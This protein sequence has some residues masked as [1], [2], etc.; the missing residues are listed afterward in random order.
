[1][2]QNM[3][4]PHTD[5]KFLGIASGCLAFFLLSMMLGTSKMVHGEH[6][7][8]EIVFYRNAL[9]A[10]VLGISFIIKKRF[11]LFKTDRPFVL[12]ARV[13]VGSVGL[14]TTFAAVQFLP[15][16]TATTIFFVSTLIVPIMAVLFLKETIGWHRWSAIAVGMSAVLLIAQPSPQAPLIGIGIAFVAAFSHA[17]IQVLLRLLRSQHPFMVTFYFMLGGAIIA[18]LF[19][20]WLASAPTF[21]SA[22]LLFIVALTGGSAQYFLTVAFKYAPASLI[23][24][25]NYTGLIWASGFD[26]FIFHMVPGWNIYIGAAMIIAAQLYIIYRERKIKN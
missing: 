24:P 18:G 3:M 21:R 5:R 12:G 10:L 26:I 2:V 19:M 7:V 4:T 20:P 8:I 1:M 11:D 14:M 13:A 17:T 23:S 15:M 22:W 9:P 25:F 16:A 6:H